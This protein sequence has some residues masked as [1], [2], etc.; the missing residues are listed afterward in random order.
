MNTPFNGLDLSLGTLPML[1]NAR[2]RSISA[3]NPTG[4]KSGGGREPA[5]QNP[6]SRELGTGWKVRPC[7]H[8]EPGQTLTLAD[9]EGPGAIQQIWMTPTGNY[10]HT[11]LRF[12]WDNEETPSIEVPVGDFFASAYTSFNRFAQI[13]SLAV[14][15]NP[16]NAFNCYW[17]MP[18]RRRAR[19]TLEN[20]GVEKMCIFYQINYTLTDVPE[21]AATLHA[22]FRRE[23]PTTPG[24]VYTLLDGVQGNGHYVGTYMAWQVNSNGWWGEGEIKFY[25]DDDL[26]P[27]ARVADH[28]AEHGGCHFP[29]ICGTGTEDYFCGSYN[30]EDKA[31]RQYREFTTPYAGMPHVVRPDGLYEANTRFSLYRW[32]IADPVRFQRQL[33]VTMQAIGWRAGGR[34]NPARDDISSTAFWYQAEPHAAF[35]ALPGRNDLEIV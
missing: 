21:N 8:I 33:A 1:S 4:E 27:G 10:R 7:T 29:T 5:S 6:C 28:V 13:S 16:G 20:I 35:P 24:R 19:V 18:F 12:Y 15:V 34:Y 11:L 2:T 22:Q 26:P 31:T 25:L 30:F 23:N 3:E 9:I 14:C 32:H 17:L